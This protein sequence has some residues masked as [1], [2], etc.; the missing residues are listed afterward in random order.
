MEPITLNKMLDDKDDFGE[1]DPP[2][3][4]S[5]ENRNKDMWQLA[6]RLLLQAREQFHEARAAKD[7]DTRLSLYCCALG[8]WTAAST[9]LIY[10]RDRKE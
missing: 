6:G 5:K 10:L 2:E 1:W 4:L 9:M 7:P 8:T 3:T